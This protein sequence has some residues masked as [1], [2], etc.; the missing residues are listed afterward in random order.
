VEIIAAKGSPITRSPLSKIDPSY[1]GK[2]LVGSIYRDGQWQIAV[3]N[4]C[5]LP[6]E[7]AIVVCKSLHMKD[8][9]KLFLG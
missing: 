9:H 1:Y 2:I 8:V 4:T 3:G 6:N 5:I 7:R